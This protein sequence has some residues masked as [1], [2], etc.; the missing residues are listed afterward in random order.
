[1]SF[2]IY[3]RTIIR[4]PLPGAG[5]TVG[6]GAVQEQSEKSGLPDSSPTKVNCN[7]QFFVDSENC[8]LFVKAALTLIT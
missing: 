2:T 5:D 4:T 8:E 3:C 7:I 1:M 6:L